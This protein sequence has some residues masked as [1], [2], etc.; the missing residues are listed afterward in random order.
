MAKKVILYPFILKSCKYIKDP[1]WINIFEELCYGNSPYGTY[2]TKDFL[3]CSYTGKEFSY[4]I[5]EKDPEIFYNEVY[6]LLSKKLG[7]MS[8]TEKDNKRRRFMEIETLNSMHDKNWSDIK[9]KSNKEM[10]VEKYV[11]CMKKKHNLTNEKSKWLLSNIILHMF[12]KLITS[13][14]IVFKDGMISEITSIKYTKNDIHFTKSL[15]DIN[16]PSKIIFE[17]S[18]TIS[19]NWYKYVENIQKN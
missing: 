18:K 7:F 15:E 6:G 5:Q 11:I 2:I 16:P 13:K 8:N 19:E 12:L 10:L 9:K 3:T 14:D 1:Y 4:K 17:D